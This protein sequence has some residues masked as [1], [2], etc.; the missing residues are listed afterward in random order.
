MSLFDPPGVVFNNGTQ[1]ASS[2]QH[3]PS[4][5]THEHQFQSVSHQS[6]PIFSDN[7]SNPSTNLTKLSY[8]N[9]S[10]PSTSQIFSQPT[11]TS[12]NFSQQTLKFL[13]EPFQL[14]V[15][16]TK[17]TDTHTNYTT[18]QAKPLRH[19]LNSYSISSPFLPPLCLLPCIS[20]L[21]RSVFV[22]LKLDRHDSRT[23]LSRNRPRRPK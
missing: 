10:N 19:V 23:S 21:P 4:T 12:H 3:F 9:L 5:E 17:Q 6:S 22:V 1:N 15:F 2:T 11:S 7:L 8:T 20:P 14:S 16:T 13:S 18:P